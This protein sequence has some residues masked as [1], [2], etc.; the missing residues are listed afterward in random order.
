M[1]HRITLIPGDGIGPEITKATLEVMEATG[2]KVEWEVFEAGTSAIEKY[3]N[4]LPD[5]VINSIRRNGVCLKGPT[6]TPIAEGFRSINVALRKELDLFANV[7]PAKSF[8][9]I[10]SHYKNVDIVVIRE[11]TEDLY[12]GVEHRIGDFAAESIKI[13]TA[14]ASTR[15]AKFAFEYA[16]KEG[17]KKVTAVHK[18]NIMKLTDGLFLE[19]V[20]NVSKEYPDIIYEEIIVDNMCMQ[21]VRNPE[22]YDVILCPNLYGDI[23]S[24]LCAG[25]V[26]GL[27]VVPGANI[28]DNL[29]VFE[30]VHG[31]APDIAGKN[32]ANPTALIL[33][34][35]QMLKYIGESERGRKIEKA[36]EIV[37]KEKLCLTPDLGGNATTEEFSIKICEKIKEL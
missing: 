31:S 15:I 7:R 33:S 19:C 35:A 11:N 5:E 21:L 8:E 32:I 36:L 16:K 24:D 14:K 22:I 3:K 10:S 9:G 25:L 2:L 27:G 1:M 30:A 6:T 29:A 13:I 34:A 18:A 17:R 23:I 37:I 26:G 12:C 4:P 28:G 20:R